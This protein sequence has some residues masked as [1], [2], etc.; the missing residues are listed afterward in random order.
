MLMNYQQSID[1]IKKLTQFGMNF[2]LARIRKLLELLG[3][4]HESLK[5]VHV[6]GT[7]GKGSTSAM[8]SSILIES[9]YTVGLFT[10]PHLHS[11]RERFRI[12]G[13]MIT[14]EDL[15]S[16]ITRIKPFLE[17]MVADGF[18]HPTEFEV[19]TAMAFV[20]FFEKRVD[21]VVL[22]V[23]LGGEI[24]STNVVAEPLVS[25]ITNVAMDHMDYLGDTVEKIA[26]VKAGII[27]HKRPVVTA[28]KKPE[29]LKI[30]KERSIKENAPFY[31]IDK[32]FGV[33]TIELSSTGSVFRICGLRGVYENV[34]TPLLG[35]HQGENLSIAI[36][37]SELLQKSGFEKITRATIYQGAERV[38]WKG[39]LEIISENPL[40]LIDVAHNVDGITTLKK[41]LHTI[42]SHKPMTLVIGM[43]AD[44]EREKA[45]EII[46]SMAQRVIVTKPLS[47]RAGNWGEITGMAKKYCQRVT[48]IPYVID[49]VEAALHE[50]D[51]EGI[52]VVTGSFYMVSEARRWLEENKEKLKYCTN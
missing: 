49:A 11:Y 41:A 24:D 35:E 44:K 43:L 52:L 46:A 23:G 2:G 45:L 5:V 25:V 14:E 39:R 1:Y 22:E 7:N 15:A 50:M 17:Q 27:K 48:T 33:Q 3:N 6:G 13:E 16:I 20:Y 36:V 28:A 18:E 26:S 30:L 40:V 4:L 8:L 29:V 42:F 38:V 37:I 19:G 31:R 34:K 32:D 51:P 9:G 47:P 10:S 12:N 21:I